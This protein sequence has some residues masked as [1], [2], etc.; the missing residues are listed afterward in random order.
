MGRLSLLLQLEFRLGRAD[1]TGERFI[2]F[3]WRNCAKVELLEHQQNPVYV[4]QKAFF[5]SRN[6]VVVN[7]GVRED[8]R[9]LS[10]CVWACLRHCSKFGFCFAFDL[11]VTQ[12]C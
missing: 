10:G 7:S 11:Q 8:Y 4:A 9:K 12:L 2:F 3:Y 5:S 1:K 6:L